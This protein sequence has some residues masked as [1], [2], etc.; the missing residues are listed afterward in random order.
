MC[1]EIGNFMRIV[2]LE[3][4]EYEEC[5]PV[6][7][8]SPKVTS[9]LMRAGEGISRKTAVSRQELE[10]HFEE[11]IELNNHCIWCGATGVLGKRGYDESKLFIRC[12]NCA[13]DTGYETSE[14]ELFAKYNKL[15]EKLQEE[16][17]CQK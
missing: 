6:Q 11:I 13:M 1:K 2:F 3:G 17:P 5:L 12:T 9:L 10:E 15:V 7:T 8:H 14:K 16:E 4:G